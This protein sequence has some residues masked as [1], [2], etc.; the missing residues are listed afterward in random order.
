MTRQPKRGVRG[1]RRLRIKKKKDVA[2]TGIFN[3]SMAILSDAEKHVLDRGLKFAP[4]RRLNKFE[5]YMDVHKFVRKL[6]I[7]RYMSS[8]PV[9]AN[10]MTSLE[11]RQDSQMRPYLSPLVPWLLH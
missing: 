10:R 6:N 2:G 3:P 7:K 11:F 5:T 1:G 4:P 9:K 8:N